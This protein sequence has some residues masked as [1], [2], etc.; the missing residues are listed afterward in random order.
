ML[1]KKTNSGNH[2]EITKLKHVQNIVINMFT[3]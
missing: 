1:I 3:I 2:G